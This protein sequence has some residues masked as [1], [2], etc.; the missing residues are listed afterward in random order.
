[1]KQA[2][3]LAGLTLG[4]S[5][6]RPSVQPT[7]R[8]DLQLSLDGGT[9][10]QEVT[11]DFG[12]VPLGQTRSLVVTAT[13]VGKDTLTLTRLTLEGSDTGAFFV[14]GE[15]GDVLPNASTTATVTFGPVRSGSQATR[16]I[17]EHDA[18]AP[19][20]AANLSGSGQ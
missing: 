7:N 10:T 14:R 5:C 3:L 19:R 1:M 18:D 11:Y 2:L 16:L 20:P 6:G 13:N 17:F 12:A 4:V 8:G 9:P 15:L